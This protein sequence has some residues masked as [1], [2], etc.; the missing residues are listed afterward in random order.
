MGYHCH[1]HQLEHSHSMGVLLEQTM[2]PE[3]PYNTISD[4]SICT[5]TRIGLKKQDA[6][7]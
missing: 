6:W 5:Y 7:Y 4:R 2:K 3:G 1:G